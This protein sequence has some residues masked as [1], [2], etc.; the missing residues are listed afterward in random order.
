MALVLLS[1]S[2][3]SVDYYLECA[4]PNQISSIVYIIFI[5]SYILLLK[6]YFFYKATLYKSAFTVAAIVSVP[7]AVMQPPYTSI[8][9][10]TFIIV[11]HFYLFYLLFIN[12][13]SLHNRSLFILTLLSLAVPV[14]FYQ[15]RTM[16]PFCL[17][18]GIL[19]IGFSILLLKTVT[20]DV[21][22]LHN[23][24]RHIADTNQKL[25]HHIA[26][27]ERSNE[28]CR[29]LIVQ[30]DMELFQLSRHAS[31]AEIT[32]G[33][34]H[35]LTQPLTGIKGIAQNIIDDINYDDFDTL[36]I[37]AEMTRIS[38][39]VDKS[40]RII[41]HVRNF[42]RKMVFSKKNIDLNQVILD[43]SDLVQHQIKRNDVN[44]V[45]SLPEGKTFIAGDKLAIEQL[46]VNLLINARDAILDRRGRDTSHQGEIF[47]GTS[48]RN[49]H[50]HLAI[51]DNGSGI[52]P[53]IL[54]KIWSP[55]FTTKKK[56][57][58]TGIGLSLS[59]KIVTEHNG[60]ISIDS[61]EQGTTFTVSFPLVQQ[62]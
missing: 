45:F 58:G 18:A 53:R 5:I 17:S 14:L 30:K 54:N 27:L 39:L 47:I 25:T 9:L 24:L 42:S 61:S 33:I 32:T 7:V 62:P 28:Q 29:R 2:I 20:H 46:I 12:R 19:N 57:H 34:T 60:T 50:V 44:L 51:R 37:V 6:Q 35:E 16:K 41:D 59:K 15:S 31:L 48:I 1:F 26:R 4:L 55:F 36:Q 38:S 49:D 22:I 52:P 10:L 56:K 8:L 23:K 11:S 13:L 40:T 21:H 3:L 43:A